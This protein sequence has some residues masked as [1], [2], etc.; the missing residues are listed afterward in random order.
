MEYLK[1][2]PIALLTGGLTIALLLLVDIVKH[3]SAKKRKK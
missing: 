1:F 3:S 2:F